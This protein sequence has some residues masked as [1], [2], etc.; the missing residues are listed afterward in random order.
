[1]RYKLLPDRLKGY[2]DYIPS[3]R[4]KQ[5]QLRARWYRGVGSSIGV[6]LVLSMPSTHPTTKSEQKGHEFKNHET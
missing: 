3:L 2:E 5:D 4:A 6:G 1:M